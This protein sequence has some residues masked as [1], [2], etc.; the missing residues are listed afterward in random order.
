MSVAAERIERLT[1]L[2]REAATIEAVDV[3]RRY[4]RLARRI[5]ERHRLTLPSSLARNHC[6]NCD[7][8]LLPGVTVRIRVHRGRL[9]YTCLECKHI[10]RYPY[11]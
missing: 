7:V 1:A 6:T 3:S 4:V 9:I 2:A 8:Y 11:E 5:A 10:H